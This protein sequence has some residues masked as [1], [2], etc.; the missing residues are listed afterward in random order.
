MDAVNNLRLQLVSSELNVMSFLLT[1]KKKQRVI[2]GK[3]TE[4]MYS[5][6]PKVY[7]AYKKS[8]KKTAGDSKKLKP[9][10]SAER[11]VRSSATSLFLRLSLTC[12]ICLTS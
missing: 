2:Y 12:F 1:S 9:V 5:I 4:C 10:S 7:E 6:D 3:W 8:D 11:L